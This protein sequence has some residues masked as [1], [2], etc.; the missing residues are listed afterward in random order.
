MPFGTITIT[1]RARRLIDEALDAGRVSSGR[2]VGEFERKFARATGAAHAV[3]VSSGTDADILALAVLHDLGARRGDEVIVPA[4]SFVATGNAVL[5]AGFKPVFVDVERDTLNI[6][7]A[8]IERAV[9]RRTRALMPVHLMGKPADMDAINRIARRRK[10]LVVE[11]AAEAHGALYKG[12]PVGG[13][14]DLGAF[15]TYIAH[16]ITTIEGGVVTTDRPE[17]AAI[18]RSLR[19]HGRACQCEV[20]VLNTGQ[21]EFCPRR[22]KFGQGTDIRFVFERIGYSCKMNELEAAVGLGSLDL[23]RGIIAKR[24][25]NLLALMRGLRRFAPYLRTFKEEK[26]ERIG[27]HAFPIILGEDAPFSRNELGEFLEKNGIETRHLFSSMP[28]QCPGFRFL[29]YRKGQFPEAEYLGEN[30][31]HVGVHQDLG[32]EHVAYLLETVERFL[33]ARKLGRTRGAAR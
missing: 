6:D 30:G 26:H 4:L 22:F 28:T 17:F 21:A 33:S 23:Y 14:G 32:P 27:P 16:I 9:T 18:L 1:P 10:L 7:P 12:R 11:D 20:C 24:R 25:R 2:L 5:H 3:A 29:G 19:S 8:R 13:L 15:S 31:L